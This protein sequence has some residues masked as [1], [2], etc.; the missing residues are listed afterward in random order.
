MVPRAR[1]TREGAKRAA[2]RKSR[3]K[4]TGSAPDNAQRIALLEAERDRLQAS[5]ANAE[6]RLAELEKSRAVVVDRIGWII[7]SLGGAIEKRM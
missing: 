4:V 1:Q 3:S 6:A 5:L 2:P 7:D